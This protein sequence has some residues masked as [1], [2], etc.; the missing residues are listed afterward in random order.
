M[1]RVFKYFLSEYEQGRTPNPDVLCNR[2][3]KF[4][5]FKE[6][7]VVLDSFADQ[8][9]IENN[10]E[11]LNTLKMLFPNSYICNLDGIVIG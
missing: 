5:E 9:Y 10:E 6:Y 1:D 8:I 7:D 4:K 11:H 2:E 3:I